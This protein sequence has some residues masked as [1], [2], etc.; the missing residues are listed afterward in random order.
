MFTEDP[1]DTTVLL[2]EQAIFSCSFLSTHSFPIWIATDGGNFNLLNTD[3][4]VRYIPVNNTMVSLGVTA[5]RARDGACY[6]C[7][8]DSFTG[9]IQSAQG[10]LTVLGKQ[11]MHEHPVPSCM[12]Q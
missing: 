10:C 1:Q 12:Q 11:S 5:T 6:Y 7:V 8:I 4:D 9:T 2:G 3:G